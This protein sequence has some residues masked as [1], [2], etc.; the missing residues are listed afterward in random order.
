MASSCPNHTACATNQRNVDKAASKHY[1]RGILY[2]GI[3]KHWG[4]RAIQ[5]SVPKVLD[6]HRDHR[7]EGV[8]ILNV[9]KIDC[10]NNLF[11]DEPQLPY[12][13]FLLEYCEK[14]DAE[15]VQAQ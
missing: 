9:A 10:L 5:C 12:L 6:C 2:V 3:E 13:R 15:K 8:Q 1:V 14:R 11:V 7:Y 4:V